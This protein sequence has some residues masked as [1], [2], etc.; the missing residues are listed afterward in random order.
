MNL[1]QLQKNLISFLAFIFFLFPAFS[2]AIDATFYGE[3]TDDG[4]DPNLLV[5]FEYGENS[6]LGYQT[7]SQRKYGTG[8]FTATI[9]NLKSCTTYY[10][11]ACVKHENQSDTS[12]GELKTFTTKCEAVFVD[13]KANG[14]DGLV[15]IDEGKPLNLSW[16]SQNAERCEA[17]GDWSGSKSL[18]GSE[19][20]SNLTFGTKTF[21]LICYGKGGEGKDSVLVFVRKVLGFQSPTVEKSVRNFSQGIMNFY[22]NITA[23]P[24]DVLEFQ[25]KIVANS[26]MKNVRIKE[27]LPERMNIRSNSLKV[28]NVLIGGDLKEGISLG[29]LKEGET[30]IVSYSVNLARAESFGYG[31]TNLMNKVKVYYDGGEITDSALVRVIKKEILSSATQAP[32]GFADDLLFSLFPP[33]IFTLF[34]LFLFKEKILKLEEFLEKKKMEYKIFKAQK[35]LNSEIKKHNLKKWFD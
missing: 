10:Y 35:T 12:C 17:S 7:Q 2:F 33:L 19:T 11:K 21:T 28:N 26:E 23:S 32:T 9:S 4:G 30:K 8:E 27:E 14:Y 16:T 25:V 15:S 22:K 29:D 31:Q 5:W 18:S 20:I 6:N 34:L 24:G 3:V 1:N 13:L